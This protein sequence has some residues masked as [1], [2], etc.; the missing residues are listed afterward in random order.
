VYAIESQI[1]AGMLISTLFLTYEEVRD[2][3]YGS[4]G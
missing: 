1:A 4:I 2:F 3:G